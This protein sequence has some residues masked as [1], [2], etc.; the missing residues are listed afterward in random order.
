MNIE[1][2]TTLW[3]LLGVLFFLLLGELIYRI[4]VAKNLPIRN[5]ILSLN[6]LL[7]PV[8]GFRPVGVR[9]NRDVKHSPS[10]PYDE[11]G[12]A[13]FNRPYSP[14]RVRVSSLARQFAE[15]VAEDNER[16]IAANTASFVAAAKT[17]GIEAMQLL[18]QRSKKAGAYLLTA[19]CYLDESNTPGEVKPYI[20]VRREDILRWAQEWQDEH[21]PRDGTDVV[22]PFDHY[23]YY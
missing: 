4:F 16:R 17:I 23:L 12:E 19:A 21:D 3:T 1:I 11:L 22:T 9:R 15:G 18:D 6:P 13:T 8:E 7:W 2:W 20:L 5:F 14:A 10:S